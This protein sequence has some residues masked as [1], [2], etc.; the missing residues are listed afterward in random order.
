M[1]IGQFFLHPVYIFDGVGVF[2][3]FLLGFN[4][5]VE[6]DEVV[7]AGDGFQAGFEVSCSQHALRLIEK[8]SYQS[9][10]EA[11][12]KFERVGLINNG[13]KNNKIGSFVEDGELWMFDL[14]ER[15]LVKFVVGCDFSMVLLDFVPDLTELFVLIA[16][17]GFAEQQAV[18]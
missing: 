13:C 2:E 3:I 5:A 8:C 14:F 12:C 4:G 17:A 1:D 18:C 11:I 9:V 10:N 15:S 16:L 7:I 6:F